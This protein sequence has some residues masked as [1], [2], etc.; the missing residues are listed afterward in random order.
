M[1]N[2]HSLH[3]FFYKCFFGVYNTNRMIKWFFFGMKLGLTNTDK[4][5][6]QHYVIKFVSDLRQVSGFLSVLQFPP[7]IKLTATI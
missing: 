1:Y 5:G 7:S 2:V 4:Q 6:V 3:V